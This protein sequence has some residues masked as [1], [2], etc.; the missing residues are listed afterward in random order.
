MADKPSNQTPQ[1]PADIAREAFRR[2]AARRIVP[3]PDAYREV[4]DE[5]AGIG[6]QPNAESVL[7]K[8]ATQLAEMPGEIGDLGVRFNRAL[9]TRD[10]KD[11]SKNLARLIDMRLK[12]LP[13]APVAVPAPAAT[14]I[15]RGIEALG[16]PASEA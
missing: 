14:P 9:S 1:N 12:K 6:G 16:S 7:T 3:T 2:L 10:W 11:Y 13:E 8:F 15:S 4:Y 5:V